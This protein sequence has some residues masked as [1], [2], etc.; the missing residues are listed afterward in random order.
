[1]SNDWSRAIVV[2][3]RIPENDVKELRAKRISLGPYVRELVRELLG[4]KKG[5]TEWKEKK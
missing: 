5:K 4:K 1:M 3:V 2:A